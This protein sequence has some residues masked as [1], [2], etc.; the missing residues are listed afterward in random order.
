MFD[1]KK[2]RTL[3]L[4]ALSIV[5]WITTFTLVTS[6]RKKNDEPKPVKKAEAVVSSTG[7]ETSVTGL[8]KF[9]QEEKGPVKLELEV[10]VPSRANQSVAVHIHEHGGCGNAGG[11]AHGHWNPTAKQHGQWGSSSYHAGDIGNITL[12]A[13]GKGKLVLETTL[14]SIGGDDNTN[15][16]NKGIIIHGGVDDYTTQPTGNSGPR[17]GCGMIMQKQ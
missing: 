2:F 12:D 11:D 15:I 14:W 7:A 1:M 6:C 10:S 9:S 8:L 3:S 13:N 16:L 17:I 5:L 4:L